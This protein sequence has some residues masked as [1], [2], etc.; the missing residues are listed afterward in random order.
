VDAGMTRFGRKG[1]TGMSLLVHT[2]APMYPC[3]HT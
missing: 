2:E 1:I 3:A